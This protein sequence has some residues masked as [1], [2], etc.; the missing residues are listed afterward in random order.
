MAQLLQVR[1]VAKGYRRH[2]LSASH[3]V[4]HAIDLTLRRGE[5]A[6]LYGANGSGKT[7]LTRLLVGL[8]SQDQGEIEVLGQNPAKALKAGLI[9]YV[10]ERERL[11]GY[12]TATSMLRVR[13]RTMNQ[14]SDGSWLSYL[15]EVLGLESLMHRPIRE[16]SKGQRQRVSILLAIAPLPPLVIMD[17]PTDG[18]DP[19][20]RVKVRDI[21]RELSSRN[22]GVLMNSHLVDETQAACESYAILHHGVIQERGRSET[23]REEVASW[24]VSFSNPPD[25]LKETLSRLNLPTTDER[26]FIRAPA[27]S[28]EELNQF[29][30][31]AQSSGLLLTA[32]EPERHPIEDKLAALSSKEGKP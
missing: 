32:L 21:I 8:T 30:A 15:R 16:L 29:I 13:L 22:V 31:L 6:G 19:V 3:A 18:L 5:V 11:P 25:S 2:F 14:A 23:L 26:G 20:S 4:L 28:I 17:E 24:Q 12:M 7:T 10:P 1:Q 27:T 9:G